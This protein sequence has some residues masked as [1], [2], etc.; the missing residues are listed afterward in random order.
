MRPESSLNVR[1]AVSHVVCDLQGKYEGEILSD[2]EI[3]SLIWYEVYESTPE[4]RNEIT[5]LGV[6]VLFV[7]KSS[8]YNIFTVNKPVRSVE[9]IKGLKLQAGS[10]PPH[11][12]YKA[13]GAA[14]VRLASSGEWF[15]SLERGII[16]GISQ[17]WAAID[18]Y[19]AA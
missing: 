17:A 7:H 8:G 15:T 11:E 1:H 14:P 16:D 18:S 6:K 12:M 3:N 5:G 10:G 9:D 13:L 19:I 2:G 4:I